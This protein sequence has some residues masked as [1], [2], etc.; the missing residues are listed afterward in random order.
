MGVKAAVEADH[1]HGPGV[2]HDLEAGFYAVN[3]Q[4]DGLFAEDRL[5]GA[6]EGFDQVGMGV[7]RRADHHGVDI[8]GGQDGVNLSHLAAVLIGYGLRRRFHG[9]R[10]C[11]QFRAG[12]AGH[13]L[14]MN[15]ADAAG[16]QKSK[17]YSH[18]SLLLGA[19]PG[20]ILIDIQPSPGHCTA[21]GRKQ[22]P[23]QT[24][25][26]CGFEQTQTRTV[27]ETTLSPSGM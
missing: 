5:A 19:S 27:Q 4:V 22:A 13:C 9:I 1:Q 20:T 6:G 2:A 17:S 10:H 21:V 18:R 25:D 26:M 11:H 12:V 14:G 3:R 23:G 24:R 15:L 7:G 8:L 16:A